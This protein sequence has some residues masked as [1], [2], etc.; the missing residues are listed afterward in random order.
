M[1][2]GKINFIPKKITLKKVK[3]NFCNKKPTFVVSFK[4]PESSMQYHIHFGVVSNTKN[5]VLKKKVYNFGARKSNFVASLNLINH[6]KIMGFFVFPHPCYKW[7]S[8]I[9]FILLLKA[10]RGEGVLNF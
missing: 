4:K 9:I 3:N 2:K 6:G 8:I 7:T 1:E 10:R 5:P